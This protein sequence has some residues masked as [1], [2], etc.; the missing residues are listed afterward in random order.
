MLVLFYPVAEL[1][2]SLARK[3]ASKQSPFQPDQAHLHIKLYHI[4]L[5]GTRQAAPSQQPRHGDA[6]DLLAQP[7]NIAAV[8]LHL[9][10]AAGHLHR[11][12]VRILPPLQ[13]GHT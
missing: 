5:Q 1:V 12:P 8:G 7:R 13:P 6:G 10:P 2:Y 11:L 3:V 4:F 9:A